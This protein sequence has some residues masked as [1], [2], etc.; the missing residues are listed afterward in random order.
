VPNN[1][2]ILTVLEKSNQPVQKL[3]SED[4]QINTRAKWWSQAH[5]ISLTIE[6]LV[7]TAQ[8]TFHSLYINRSGQLLKHNPTARC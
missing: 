5:T 2:T 7:P 1:D 4:T 3:K 6:N 8:N